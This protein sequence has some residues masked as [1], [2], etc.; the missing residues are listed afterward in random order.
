MSTI[1]VNSI[2]KES[3]STLTIGG[4]GTTVNVSNMV[5]D[6]ALS[7]RN[8]IINGAMQVAQRGT[9]ETGVT[10]SG[11]RT[12][13]RH[14]LGLVTLGTW[15]V[16]QSTDSPNGFSNSLK[17][18]CTTADAS[19]A[20]GDIAF[21]THR[22]EGQ[23]LQRL[24]FGTADAKT[25]TVSF[26][27][28]SN[29]TGA[30]SFGVGQIDNSNKMFSNSYTIN[31]AN[32]WEYKTISIPADTAGQIDNDNGIGLEVYWWL[33][34]GSNWM[35]GSYATTWSTYDATRRNPSNLGVGG[36]VS[37]YFAITGIQLEVGDVATPFEHESYGD[38]LAKCQRYYHTTPNV[39]S[40]GLSGDGM[41]VFYAV[42]ANEAFGSNRFPVPMRATPTI[43]MSDNS[44]TTGSVHRLAVG[45][46]GTGVV[47]QWLSEKAWSKIYKVSA[48]AAT[49]GIAANFSAD[50]EL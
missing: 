33:N 30:A 9:Q 26:W 47:A 46:T 7:N 18:T 11:Y 12:C 24:G 27:V 29:K 28:K 50:A 49:N 25:M 45:D 37:D 43:T 5:P 40:G 14:R 39:G 16:D 20:A 35:G 23:N 17:F 36:A 31:S 48:W 21:L 19:P 3:G 15:T 22:I 44:G 2:D 32:T 38:T 1:N 8:I 4:S 10:G 13:D 41:F 42:N 34:S 6:V